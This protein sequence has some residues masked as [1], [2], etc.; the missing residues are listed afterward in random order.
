MTKTG[1]L[2]YKILTWN[3]CYWSVLIYKAQKDRILI[4]G[5]KFTY[6]FCLKRSKLD[7][8]CV[9]SW[10]VLLHT[11]S[12]ALQKII[13]FLN[14]RLMDKRMKRRRMW[15]E[16]T[17]I[18]FLKIWKPSL[19]YK[20]LNE[21]QS[22]VQLEPWKLALKLISTIKTLISLNC[23][24]LR[25]SLSRCPWVTRIGKTK[26]MWHIWKLLSWISDVSKTSKAMI[27]YKE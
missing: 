17:H 10:F 18:V 16:F 7:K 12:I 5:T 11:R 3:L 24:R 21:A 15:L 8:G 19:Y 6:L 22:N 20:G 1:V 27:K 2:F 23:S 25:F 4:E 13:I 26:A 9:V 14:S